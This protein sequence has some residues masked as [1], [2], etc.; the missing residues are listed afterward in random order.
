MDKALAQVPT[1]LGFNNHM[2]SGFTGRRDA[3][4]MLAGLAYGRGLFVLDSVTRGNSQLETS[5]V[6]Q[7]I[8]TASR[9][10]FLDDPQG[11]DKVLAA[12]DK[13]ARLDPAGPG[14]LGESRGRGRGAPAALCLAS[15]PAAGRTV[16]QAGVIFPGASGALPG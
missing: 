13:S 5:M 6:R 7:G 16:R 11:T 1:A 2:G 4:R 14:A 12:L 9:H 3:C 10:V 8:V 15:G